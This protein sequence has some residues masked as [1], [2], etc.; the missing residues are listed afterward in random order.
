MSVYVSDEGFVSVGNVRVTVDTENAERN[1]AGLA[2]RIRDAMRGTMIYL[3]R[4]AASRMRSHA[5]H[6]GGGLNLKQHINFSLKE[7]DKAIRATVRPLG[8][9]RVKLAAYV[10]EGGFAG[11]VHQHTRRPPGAR[12][13]QQGSIRTRLRFERKGGTLVRVKDYRRTQAA[14]PFILPTF[15]AMARDAEAAI[16][17]AVSRATRDA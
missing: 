10:L 12:A 15:N 5:P 13:R 3:G 2:T 17:N 4:E 8:S 9:Q 6:Y 7:T 11:T 16:I 1:V 14:Q